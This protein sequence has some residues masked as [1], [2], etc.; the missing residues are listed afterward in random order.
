MTQGRA[1]RAPPVSA[2][3]CLAPSAGPRPRIL[4]QPWATESIDRVPRRV[5]DKA[6][7]IAK[8]FPERTSWESEFLSQHGHRAG[9]G[10]S[11][12][13]RS[14]IDLVLQPRWPRAGR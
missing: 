11:D 4:R 1:G 14:P 2:R 10:E 6:S 9:G 13:A 7:K 5:A 12:A 8:R 3:C